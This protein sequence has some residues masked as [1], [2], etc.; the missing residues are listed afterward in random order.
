MSQ[1]LANGIRLNYETHGDASHPTLVMIRGLGTQMVEWHP[2]L[3]RALTDLGLHVVVFDNRDVGLSEKIADRG[4]PSMKEVAAD[5]T[6]APYTLSDMAADVCGLLDG[7]EIEQAH[8]LGISLGG[9]IAQV[10]TA[11]FPSRVSS[12]MSVMSSSG[13]KGLPGPTDAAQAAFTE[14]VPETLEAVIEQTARHKVIFGSPGYPEPEAERLRDARMAIERCHYPEGI[15]RQRL[16]AVSQM[17]RSEMLQ[18]IH[19]PTTVIHGADDALIPLACGQD[20]ANLIP[21]A[22]FE[23]IEGMGH[24]I[25]E[26]LVPEFTARVAKHLTRVGAIS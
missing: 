18:T 21:D 16:A 4:N 19:I 6:R 8:I 12:L 11:Q 9:M 20:T 22:E 13:S 26:L 7:L 3:I 15:H 17:N 24:N 5:G 2:H 25:P 1:M 23:A 10:M 14:A